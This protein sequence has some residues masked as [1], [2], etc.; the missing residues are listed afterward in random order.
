MNPTTDYAVFRKA[1]REIVAA[2]VVQ[3]IKDWEDAMGKLEKDESDTEAADTV[4]EVEEFLN[5]DQYELF[6]EF[7]NLPEKPV[8][9]LRERWYE[10]HRP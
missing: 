9:L 5:S 3:A 4:K 10:L 8:Q 2:T 7:K 1:Y 6:R